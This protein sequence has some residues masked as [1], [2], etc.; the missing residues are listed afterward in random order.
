VV[1]RLALAGLC[2]LAACAPLEQAPDFAPADPVAVLVRASLD[3]RGARPTTDEVLRVAADPA[4]LDPMIDAFLQDPRFGS[5][6][7]DLY[8]EVLLTRSEQW[9]VPAQG[10][11]PDLDP[12]RFAASVG[13]EVPRMVGRVADED[14]PFTDL[15]VG[16]WTM[17]DEVLRRIW[18]VA[19]LDAAASGWAPARYTDGRPAAGALATNSLWWRYGSTFSN[20]NRKRANAISRVFLCNDYLGRAIDFDRS[21]NLL[22]QGAVDDALRSNAGCVSCHASLDPL[23]GHLYGFWYFNENSPA[24]VSRYHPDR[25]PLWRDLSG[26]EPGYYGRPSGTLR[27]LGVHVASDPRFPQCAVQ[28]FTEQLLRRPVTIADEDRLVAHREAFLAGGLTVRA[29]VRSVV[30]SPEYRA[31]ATDDP[32]AVPRKL[33]TADLLHDQVEALTGFRW[34]SQGRDLLRSEQVGFRALA[35][36]ADGVFVTRSATRPS[37]TFLLV[38]E[39]LAEAAAEHVVTSDFAGPPAAARLLRHVGPDADLPAD[40]AAVVA[41]IRHLHLAIFGRDVAEDGPEVEANL[42]LFADL[43]AL[44]GPPPRAWIGLV[45]ALLRDPDFVLY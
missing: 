24:E 37:A 10:Y 42:A 12:V 45:S 32:R 20:A 9:P 18:P 41:Q 11:A 8:A 1:R 2:A 21:V 27:E 30:A 44:G 3:L 25:E 4:A 31:G 6:M 36:G 43:R 17:A 28:T 22:D 34:T 39:R 14:L 40:R 35:G 5:R 23:A 13:D 7:A 38:Q 15:V 29:I 16:D 19:P 26:V 33:V